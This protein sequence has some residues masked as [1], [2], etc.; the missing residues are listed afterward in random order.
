MGHRPIPKHFEI[1][2]INTSDP[3]VK[4]VKIIKATAQLREPCTTLQCTL[5]LWTSA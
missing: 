1:L 3:T 5:R 2:V 4:L